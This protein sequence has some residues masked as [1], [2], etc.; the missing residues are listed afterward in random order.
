MKKVLII[1]GSSLVARGTINHYIRESLPEKYEL[2]LTVRKALKT[3]IGP[4]GVHRLDLM[5]NHSLEDLLENITP[6][7]FIYIASEGRIDFS[8]QNRKAAYDI[9]V[10][11]LNRVVDI[12]KEKEVHFIYLSTNAV[13]S[14]LHP[15]YDE[16]DTT[17]PANYYG[18][19][20][21]DA[22]EI[23]AE[24]LKGRYTIV[25]P[26]LLLGLSHEGR[27]ETSIEFFLK[28]LMKNERVRVV[29]DIITNPLHTNFLGEGI[30]RIVENRD[31]SIGEIFHFGGK[32]RL[33]RYRLVLKTCACLGL[34]TGLVTPVDSYEFP[35]LTRRM[36]DT[37]FITAKAE[38]TLGWKPPSLSQ[39][40]EELKKDI[41]MKHG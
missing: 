19:T 10:K 22:E 1:G 36:P 7:I 5:D 3:L 13:F 12:I 39:S 28:R 27:R 18:E 32:E 2:H 35:E 31:M 29:D 14:G 25:R 20:K 23:V 30:W 15:P 8:E 41:D 40:L 9:N 17:D 34:D 26:T 24:K 33:S 11:A 6:D 37:T 21:R 4:G 38:K 16:K